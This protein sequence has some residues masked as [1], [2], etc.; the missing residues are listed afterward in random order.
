MRLS[1]II[2]Q[3]NRQFIDAG[4]QDGLVWIGGLFK[5]FHHRSI[6]GQHL[7]LEPGEAGREALLIV[8]GDGQESPND[9]TVALSDAA[10]RPVAACYRSILIRK[11]LHWDS[12]GAGC[13]VAWFTARWR[14]LQ[15]R[16]T[17]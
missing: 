8:G 15:Q 5:D 4:I 17:W 9:L 16:L 13:R 10:G 14:W 1:L 11:R 6:V 12:S 7:G 2:Y 3:W